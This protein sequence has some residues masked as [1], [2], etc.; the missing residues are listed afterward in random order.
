[1]IPKII[2]WI[3][4]RIGIKGMFGRSVVEI[5]L[6]LGGLTLLYFGAMKVWNELTYL[7]KHYKQEVNLKEGYK[8]DLKLLNQDYK[9]LDST[10]S[11]NLHLLKETRELKT[12]DSLQFIQINELHQINTQQLAKTNRELKEKINTYHESGACFQLVKISDGFLK[13]K[14][15]KFIEIDCAT[16]K[17]L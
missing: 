13:P 3:V 16:L 6:F 11:A 8:N 12:K 4:K 7:N 2:T 9:K 5:V 1:M 15:E 10:N 14:I 17:E